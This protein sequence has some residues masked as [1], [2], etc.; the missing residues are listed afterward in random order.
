MHVQSGDTL[1]VTTPFLLAASS[2]FLQT[3]WKLFLI[4]PHLSSIV[5]T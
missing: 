3:Y 2:N 5:A 4:N 1:T